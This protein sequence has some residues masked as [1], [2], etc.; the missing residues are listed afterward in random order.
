MKVCLIRPSVVYPPGEIFAALTP[1]IG[2]AYIA[3]ALRASG[4]DVSLIDGLGESLDIRHTWENNTY[5]YGLSFQQILDRIPKDVEVIGVHAGF[6]LD[7]PACRTLVNM[8]GKEFPGVPLVGGGEHV[9]ALP[10]E[11]LRE[12]AFNYLV[13][14]EGEETSAEFFGVLG[15][16]S[17][18]FELI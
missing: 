1:P 8:I 7:W 10:E 14:G 15:G 6:S 2:V 9:T 18:D 17:P 16:D 12:S 5:L 11:S 4:H 3:G 13:L